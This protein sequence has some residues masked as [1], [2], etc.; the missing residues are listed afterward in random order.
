MKHLRRQGGR[1]LLT[2][3]KCCSRM[4]MKK[5]SSIRYPI[6]PQSLAPSTPSSRDEQK[7]HDSE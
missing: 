4:K 7:M 1:I 6:V 3:R 2:R 5:D